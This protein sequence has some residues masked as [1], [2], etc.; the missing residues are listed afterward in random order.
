MEAGA[1]M[2]RICSCERFSTARLIDETRE[3][4][5]AMLHFVIVSTDGARSAIGAVYQPLIPAKAHRRIAAM[6]AY[7]F[8]RSKLDKPTVA[9]P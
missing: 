8:Q 2:G 4:G 9:N 5:K 7:R 1:F 6:V 3:I